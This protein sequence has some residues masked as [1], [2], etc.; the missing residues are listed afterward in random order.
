VRATFDVV[1]V[2]AWHFSISAPL[3]GGFAYIINTGPETLDLATLRVV[4]VTDD[5]AVAV[6]GAT[7]SPPHVMLSPGAAAMSVVP[8]LDPL[9]PERRITI[10]PPDDIYFWLDISGLS[11]PLQETV[12]IHATVTISLDDVEITL[13]T[14]TLNME[15]GLDPVVYAE[16]VSGARVAAFR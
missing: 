11:G 14:M 9:V 13:P 10:A 12:D 6:V 8:I 7:V 4:S 2:S 5:H 16:A 15:S 1:Y 3:V